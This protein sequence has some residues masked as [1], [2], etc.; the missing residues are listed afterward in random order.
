MQEGEMRIIAT[1]QYQGVLKMVAKIDGFLERIPILVKSYSN[2][3]LLQQIDEQLRQYG[4]LD[5]DLTN[6]VFVQSPATTQQSTLLDTILSLCTPDSQSCS[7][8]A[9]TNQMIYDFYQHI[10]VSVGKGA[11]F[12]KKCY[13]MK[14]ILTNRK[15]NIYETKLVKFLK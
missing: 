12:Q 15:Y 2:Q 6:L 3:R 8:F 11:Y 5:N 14:E 7:S 4:N 1:V 9:S 10:M 13:Q